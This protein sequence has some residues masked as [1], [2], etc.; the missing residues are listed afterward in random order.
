M[1]LPKDRNNLIFAGILVLFFSS[2]AVFAYGLGPVRRSLETKTFRVVPGEGFRKITF[3][4]QEEG[5]IRSKLAFELLAFLS[6]RAEDLKPG[7]YELSPNLGSLSI[8][9]YLIK[10]DKLV[11]D[12]VIPE[13]ASIYDIDRILSEK[14]V[15]SEG[16]FLVF[17][18]D[19]KLEGRLFP[20][21]YKFF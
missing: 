13:G 1:P 2:L 17:A 4:L 21:T 9:D 18:K 16:E 15:I 8:L 6:G 10:G 11:V 19:K 3:R 5:F 20:D 7:V 12:I 14:Q